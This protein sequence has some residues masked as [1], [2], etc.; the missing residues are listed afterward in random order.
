MSMPHPIVEVIVSSHSYAKQR[1]TAKIAK[2]RAAGST[3]PTRM[4]AAAAV[5]IALVI[6]QATKAAVFATL[7]PGEDVALVPIFSILPSWNEGTAFGL[8]QGAAP[9]LLIVLA[10]AISGWLATLIIKSTS[11]V[12]AAGLGAV[13]GG[14]L[15]NVA[16]RIRFG[17]VRDFI[18]LHWGSLHWPTFNGADMF[19]VGGLLLFVATDLRRQ[20]P[21][22]RTIDRQKPSDAEKIR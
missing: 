19:V 17:A 13:I 5:V 4:A 18:D 21:T 10:L 16:D 7:R 15:G 12:E 11:P 14:A 2:P 1:E 8:A 22:Q 9:L 3:R 6:D 20:S